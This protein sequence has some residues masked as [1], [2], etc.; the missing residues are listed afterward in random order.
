MVWKERLLQASEQC[1]VED[2]GEVSVVVRLVL[3]CGFEC[4]RG[5][6]V[7]GG[8]KVPRC[9]PCRGRHGGIRKGSLGDDG[10]LKPLRETQRYDLLLREE[11]DLRGHPWPR[12]AQGGPGRAPLPL[13]ILR[14]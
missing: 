9:S 13:S 7:R 14:G 3:L 1:L 2:G 8:S 4:L 12:R 11:R 6:A 10:F 5:V